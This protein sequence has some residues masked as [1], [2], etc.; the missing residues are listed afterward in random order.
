MREKT[1]DMKEKIVDIGMK[2]DMSMKTTEEDLLL[3]L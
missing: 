2:E 3:F 1:I